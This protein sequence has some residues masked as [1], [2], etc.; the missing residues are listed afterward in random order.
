MITEISGKCM[1]PTICG[2]RSE[3]QITL[4]QVNTGYDDCVLL[5]L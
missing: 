4:R 3:T 5:L 2:R 1:I